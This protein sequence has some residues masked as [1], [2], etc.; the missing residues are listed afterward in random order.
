MPNSFTMANRNFDFFVDR[1]HE[2]NCLQKAIL[3]RQSLMVCGPRGA[4]KTALVLQ[5]ISEP[6][7][8]VEKRCLYVEAAKDL[9]DLL[10][11]L[12]R[13]L[14]ESGDERLKRELHA[15]RVS[16]SNFDDWL[17]KLPTTR[18]RGTLYR[19]VEHNGYRIFLDHLPHLT[20]ALARVIKE[21][22]WM[23]QTP[24]YVIFSEEAESRLASHFFYWGEGETLRLGPLAPNAARLLI[25]HCIQTYGLDHLELEGF[26]EQV[27]DLS[28][29][30]PG[31]IVGMC[32]LAA[33]PRYQFDSRVKTK[34][35]HIDY[36]MRGCPGTV[37]PARVR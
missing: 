2:R 35:I 16:R 1:D 26:R 6:L 9:Q 23:R 21:L 37:K 22:F 5:V 4:G 19:A 12:I 17:K 28:H 25:E 11:R 13:A 29:S 15:A 18:L 7:P 31:A 27:L 34:L 32:Q 30:M 14:Y 10:R 3:T 33:D 36:L 8:V 24:V 20:P